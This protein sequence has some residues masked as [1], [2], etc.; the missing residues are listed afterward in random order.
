[1][2]GLEVVVLMKLKIWKIKQKKA[3]IYK[4]EF[5]VLKM[6]GNWAQTILCIQLIAQT[7]IMM[8]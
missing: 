1:M 4:S 8:E 7:C 2:R 3:I 6:M 5:I